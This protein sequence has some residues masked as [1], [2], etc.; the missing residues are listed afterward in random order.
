MA[1]GGEG[2]LRLVGAEQR[3]PITLR[4]EI[5][6]TGLEEYRLDEY[7]SMRDD[8]PRTS[9]YEAA[10]KRRM[11]GMEGKAV[12][13]DIGT[14]PFALLAVI[15]ARAG[16]RRVFAIEKTPAV[17]ALAREAVA[18]EGLQD[19]ITVIEG[20]SLK[21]QV[22]ERADFIVSELIGSI[23]KQEGVQRI[24][25]DAN[26]RFLKKATGGAGC[27]QHIPASC[28]TFIAPVSFR[29]HPF[30]RAK[31]EWT[32]LRLDSMSKDL[33]FLAQEQVLEDFDYC[34]PSR[35]GREEKR[36]FSFKVTREA[37]EAAGGVFSGVAMW[38]RVKM[39]EVDSIEV[40]GVRSHWAY[41]V[42]LM[43]EQAVP[44]Q[45]GSE[46]RLESRIDFGSDPVRYL[47]EAEVL[48]A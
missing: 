34:S 5:A 8:V 18:A 22:P 10:I 37:W 45:A 2:G 13:V 29:Y 46:I 44:I 20:N 6:E 17:A 41:V 40:K 11:A 48:P 1:L 23:A 3:K 38:C 16:A 31:P 42:A 12:V 19:K 24:I 7:E 47:F 15:A 25:E 21:V 27:P 39:D 33:G 30:L 28:Q 4:K 26:E 9:K 36:R 35:S 14:G 43:S 32:P